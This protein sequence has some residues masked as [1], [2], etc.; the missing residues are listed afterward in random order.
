MTATHW[1]N[2]KPPARPEGMA[3]KT[4]PMST[5]M[6]VMTDRAAMEPVKE[7][8]RDVFMASR[9]AMKK[10]LSPISDT[11]TREKACAGREKRVNQCS[12][13]RCVYISM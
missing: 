5:E 12:A 3:W 1:S 8:S 9:P 11:N 13:V 4:W 7:M 2:L 10:V 6:T